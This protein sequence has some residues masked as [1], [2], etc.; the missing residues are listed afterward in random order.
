M[1]HVVLV[2]TDHDCLDSFE[3]FLNNSQYVF[4]VELFPK[5]LNKDTLFKI[6]CD[7]EI[8]QQEKFLRMSN[9]INLDKKC[10]YEISKETLQDE[11]WLES[12]KKHFHPIVTDRLVV[13]ISEEQIRDFNKAKIIIDP[14][15]AFGNGGHPTTKGCLMMIDKYFK[16]GMNVLDFGTGSG[17]LAIACSKLGAF[18][19][20]AVDNDQLAVDVCQRN[21]KVNNVSVN[22]FFSDDFLM[23]KN[24]DLIVANIT[25]DVIIR[26]FK[27]F[28]EGQKQLKY[29]LLSGISDYRKSQM[30]IFLNTEEIVPFDVYEE[31]GWYTYLLNING[32]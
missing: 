22:A 13:G 5:E 10:K 16:R 7:D 14:G 17:V 19:V 25:V 20:D 3:L 26:F 32:G 9:F 11:D 8:S 27:S 29:L 28:I 1:K 21:V 4:S 15:M 18:F 31:N 6:Y 2:L 30:D 23:R 24:Y 12:W